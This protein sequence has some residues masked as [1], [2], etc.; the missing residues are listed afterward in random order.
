MIGFWPIA[1]F[2]LAL[3]FC[4][5]PAHQMASSMTL[6]WTQ[7]VLLLVVFLTPMVAVYLLFL[8]M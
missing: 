1:V 6:S 5:S 7:I 2:I 3:L 8:S 4:R